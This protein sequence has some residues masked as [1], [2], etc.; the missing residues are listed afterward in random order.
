MKQLIENRLKGVFRSYK[1]FRPNGDVI[2]HSVDD[3]QE[4][5]FNDNRILVISHHQQHRKKILCET[6]QW[7]IEFQNKRYFLNIAQPSMH[8][9]IISI[10]HTGL[11][12]EN[13]ARNEKVFFAQ[14][15]IWESL[16]KNRLPVL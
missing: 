12:I 7:I 6:N 3:F 5:D 16:I 14:F 8:L 13:S 10:N 15:P 11:V 4:W 9:E 1:T 2:L